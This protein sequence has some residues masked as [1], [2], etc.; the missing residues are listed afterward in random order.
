MKKISVLVVLLI[1]VAAIF[2]FWEKNRFKNDWE[3]N[4]Q[5]PNRWNVYIDDAGFLEMESFDNLNL[6]D[7]TKSLSEK[8]DF[9]YQYEDYDDMG[10]LVTQIGNKINGEDQKYWQYFVNN[11]QPQ[12]SADKYF[13]PSG[14]QI[15]WKFIESEF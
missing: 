8:Y 6:F 10:V 15:E 14:T 11:E 13:P 9:Q 5:M 2:Y 1:I 3:H 12:I 7:I 4:P